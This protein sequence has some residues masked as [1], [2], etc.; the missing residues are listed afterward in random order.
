MTTNRTLRSSRRGPDTPGG[1]LPR[2]ILALAIVLLPFTA[3]AAN[4]TV[5]VR[6]PVG[7]GTSDSGIDGLTPDGT[8]L[9]DSKIAKTIFAVCG[10]GD[11]CEVKGEVNEHGVFQSISKVRKIDTE[12]EPSA[13]VIKEKAGLI[14]NIDHLIQNGTVSI[15]SIE[16]KKTDKHI[17]GNE[18][19]WYFE[20]QLA[21]HVK[22]IRAKPYQIG[23]YTMRLVKRDG[24]WALYR[25]PLKH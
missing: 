12:I 6:G 16:I 18:T 1:L 10:F 9:T 5:T 19:Y 11:E 17:I 13:D 22:G 4:R 20:F 25:F 15:E 23:T 8:F 24:F 14:A 7:V 3:P 2:A 21:I